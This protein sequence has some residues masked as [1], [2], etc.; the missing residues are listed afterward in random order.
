MTDRFAFPPQ[1]LADTLAAALSILPDVTLLGVQP[2][3]LPEGP[4]WVVRV[5]CATRAAVEAAFRLHRVRAR[6][7]PLG[8]VVLTVEADP[9]SLE[10]SPRDA[11]AG[12]GYAS[13]SPRTAR[14]SDP[15]PRLGGSGHRRRS[16]GDG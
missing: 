5:R 7:W 16:E 3:Y 14:L 13:S 1:H 8:A 6:D 15:A 11:V 12:D 10:G 4:R 2:R 9:D